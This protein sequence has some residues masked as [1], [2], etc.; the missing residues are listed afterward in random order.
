MDNERKKE[1]RRKHNSVLKI[2]MYSQFCAQLNR[3]WILKT[4]RCLA[5]CVIYNWFTQYNSNNSGE[6]VVVF[7]LRMV[8][9]FAFFGFSFSSSSVQ[10]FWITLDSALYT[11][12]V[13]FID[14][15]PIDL[16]I[17]NDCCNFVYFRIVWLI[18]SPRLNV[19]M[20][21]TGISGDNRLYTVCNDGIYR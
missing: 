4:K 8:I 6:E 2:E 14:I 10:L 1:R 21:L 11:L 7:L 17:F 20:W 19:E 9:G 13:L 5:I 16:S 3:W 15:I 12:F 18:S